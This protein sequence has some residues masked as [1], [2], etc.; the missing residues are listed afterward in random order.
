[1]TPE[2]KGLSDNTIRVL[3][4]D[5]S[6]IYTRLLADELTRDPLLEV[7]PFE[8]DVS[9]LVASA[10]RDDIDVL[11][12]SSTLDEQPSRGL[13]LLRE[14]RAQHPKTRA[15]LLP[16]SSKEEAILQAFQAGARGIFGRNEPM[17]QL[18]KCVRCVY[19]GQI[20]ASSRDLGLALD[21]LANLPTVRA[22]NANGMSLLSERELQ[23]VQCL[24][25]GLT[26]REIAKRLQLSQHTVK[27]YFFKIFDKLGVSSRVELLFMSLSHAATEQ[28]S[29][30]QRAKDEPKDGNF[31]YESDLLMK[32]AEAGVPA[33]QLALAQ[34]YLNRRSDPQDVVNAY[35]WYLIAI[36][37]AMQARGFITKMLTV[38]QIEEARR[39]ASTWL[40]KRKQKP[41]GSTSNSLKS[42]QP[43][44]IGPQAYLGAGD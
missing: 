3:V 31:R 37:S 30:P 36:E 43:A 16:D 27:N 44:S 4:A 38:E 15:V 8:S 2:H 29:R 14:L 10:I 28:T 25:E 24:A 42:K 26:N 12:I 17:E 34:V 33:A 35:M 39:K 41:S 1:M 32:S 20:W 19:Q 9:D 11:V 40:A 6:R 13:E 23:V 7:I 5:S 18:C 22:V 21:A